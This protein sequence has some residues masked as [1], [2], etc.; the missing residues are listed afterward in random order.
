[1]ALA[2]LDRSLKAV[3]TAR[4]TLR[5]AENKL[6]ETPAMISDGICVQEGGGPL[7][8]SRRTLHRALVKGNLLK[9]GSSASKN[10]GILDH[11]SKLVRM[12]LDCSESFTPSGELQAI[13]ECLQ[14]P[15]QA[16]RGLQLAMASSD[17]HALVYS[18]V[19]MLDLKYGIKQVG[20]QVDKYLGLLLAS[21]DSKQF[22]DPLLY[23]V[24]YLMWEKTGSS[25]KKADRVRAACALTALR[26]FP[27][28]AE[29][30]VDEDD[31][32]DSKARAEGLL[33]GDESDAEDEEDVDDAASSKDSPEAEWQL[34]KADHN[35]SAESMDKL[36]ALTG[37]R[38]IKKKAMGVV[39]EVLLQKDRPASVKAETSMNFLFTGNPGCGKTVRPPRAEVARYLCLL[40]QSA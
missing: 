14:T 24:H 18:A 31:D 8:V 15:G 12:A 13:A 35:L 37:L 6:H 3:Y 29:L 30:W 27:Q 4:K 20:I 23:Y 16:A 19:A 26:C 11:S 36:M 39:K 25:S 40:A 17:P 2:G 28:V 21:T 38:E 10:A 7:A 22:I 33:E 1:M 5:W 9:P 34:A 32:L